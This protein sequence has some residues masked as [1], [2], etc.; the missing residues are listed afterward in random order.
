MLPEL[1][2]DTLLPSATA[3]IIDVFRASTTIVHALANGARVV[4]PCLTVED[5]TQL[6]DRFPRE[7]RLLGGERGGVKIPGFDLGNSPFEYTPEVVTGKDIIFT[8]TNGTRALRRCLAARRIIVGGFIN[9]SAMAT[10]LLEST[11]DVL[12]VCAGNAGHLTAED[13]LFAGS[14][15]EILTVN[16]ENGFVTDLGAELACEFTRHKSQPDATWQAA[17]RTSRGGS[18]LVFLGY[19]RD[20]E[21]SITRDAFDIVPVWDA[22]AEVIVVPA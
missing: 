15:V 2:D 10:L 20:I 12:L 3:V 16:A 14:L 7:Q 4:H 21:R 6:A 8:T 9:I 11:D 13:I 18:N 19:E 22:E 17:M 1:V 5:A